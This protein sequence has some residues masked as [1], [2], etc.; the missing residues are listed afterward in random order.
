MRQADRAGPGRFDRLLHLGNV[1]VDIVVTVPALPERGGDCDTIAAM[2]GAICGACQGVESFPEDARSTVI[3]VNAL[4]L[5]LEGLAVGLLAVRS[6]TAP[7]A[8]GD[9]AS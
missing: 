9:A 4:D 5:G 7:R 2:T 8:G 3:R 6:G 1:V